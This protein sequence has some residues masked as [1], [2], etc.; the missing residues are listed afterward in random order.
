M[1]DH[2]IKAISYFRDSP[3][4]NS[5]TIN[6]GLSFSYQHKAHQVPYAFQNLNKIPG[7]A[8]LQAQVQKRY[9]KK[10]G[11]Q[12]YGKALVVKKDYQTGIISKLEFL[13]AAYN[14]NLDFLKVNLY[15]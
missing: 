7:P 6:M 5:T 12:G 15:F 3:Y 9:R 10:A 8:H 14:N 2:N 11:G 1:K 4:S 13:K